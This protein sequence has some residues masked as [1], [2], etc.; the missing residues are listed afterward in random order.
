[1]PYNQGFGPHAFVDDL[2]GKPF[3]GVLGKGQIE[4]FHYNVFDAQ[5]A[6]SPQLLRK[7]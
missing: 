2:F 6:D 5:V 4:G 3:G 7:A 1:M